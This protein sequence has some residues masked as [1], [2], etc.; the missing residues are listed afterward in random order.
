MMMTN[1]VQEFVME[2]AWQ[3]KRRIR[4]MMEYDK[5]TRRGV[6]RPDRTWHVVALAA[7]LQL[8]VAV[9]FVRLWL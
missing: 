8:V 9:L 4:R 3:R 6:V 1:M 7:V 5:Q 2:T